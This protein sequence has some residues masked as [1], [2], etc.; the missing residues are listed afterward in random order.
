MAESYF[1]EGLDTGLVLDASESSIN[2]PK[3]KFTI[4]VSGSADET[5][6][7]TSMLDSKQRDEAKDH[8]TP[9]VTPAATARSSSFDYHIAPVK[10]PDFKY[11]PI[12]VRMVTQV[13]FHFFSTFLCR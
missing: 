7:K 1:Q 2:R 4:R 9:A 11:T 8:L 3:P 12:L 10:R 6:L 13:C 5:E